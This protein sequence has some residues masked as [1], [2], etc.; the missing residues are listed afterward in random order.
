MEMDGAA[1]SC[2]HNIRR[3][4]LAAGD[5]LRHFAGD[6]VALRRNDMRVLIR[7][8]VQDVDVA[9]I[10]Q[11]ENAVVRRVFMTLKRLHRLM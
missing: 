4:Q 1:S 8:L 11:A 6:Q 7:V 9:L 10:Q 2:L 5:I 3:N